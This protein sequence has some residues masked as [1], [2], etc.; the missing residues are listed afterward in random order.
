MNTILK[1]IVLQ[2]GASMRPRHEVVENPNRPSVAVLTSTISFNAATTRS[3]GKPV[4]STVPSG[5]FCQLQCGHD[6]KSWK[7]N[8]KASTDRMRIGYA[9]MRPRHE[10]VENATPASMSCGTTRTQLQCGHDTKSWKTCRERC[11]RVG[12]FDS[13]NAATT[14]SRGKLGHV[15]GPL[16]GRGH[17]VASMRPRHEVVENN[18]FPLVRE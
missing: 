1:K 18:A 6:T 16:D 13:F 17:A 5:R 8:A 9:S 11:R 4:I 2:G 15:G 7:T 3:R 12:T 10:V 14:R